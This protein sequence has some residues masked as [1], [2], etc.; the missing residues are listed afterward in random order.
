MKTSLVKY[1]RLFTISLFSLILITSGCG[2]DEGDV[3]SIPQSI[4]Q[5]G[6]LGTWS[7]SE[8]DI[9][10]FGHGDT[11][12]FRERI[13]IEGSKITIVN[14]CIKMGLV[15]VVSSP[16]RIEGNKLYV[17]EDQETLVEDGDN[18]CSA[19]LGKATVTFKLDGNDK[20]TWTAEDDSET[21]EVT[22]IR[23]K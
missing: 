1:S 7:F 5:E 8:E 3:S 23:K 12:V 9:A 21:I 15:A 19:S 6:A 16:I 14:E 11:S 13:Y 2:N 20:M 4:K 17:L 18:K 10:E 22:L